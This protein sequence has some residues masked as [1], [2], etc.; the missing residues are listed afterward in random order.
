MASQSGLPLFQ[1]LPAG[2]PQPQ[3]SSSAARVE[4]GAPSQVIP[5][6]H[7]S[8][9]LED[10]GVHHPR[11]PPA[12]PLAPFPDLPEFRPFS[13]CELPESWEYSF[14]EDGKLVAWSPDASVPEG[15]RRR[16][17]VILKWTNDKEGAKVLYKIRPLSAPVSTSSRVSAS[18]T[19]D[20]IGALLENPRLNPE[21]HMFIDRSKDSPAVAFSP[22]AWFPQVK[23]EYALDIPALL[24]RSQDQPTAAPP[25]RAVPPSFPVLPPPIAPEGLRDCLWWSGRDRDLPHQ[26]CEPEAKLLAAESS[27][28]Q[29]LAS[30]ISSVTAVAMM[31]TWLRTL[32]VEFQNFPLEE[33]R[34]ALMALSTVAEGAANMVSVALPSAARTFAEACLAARLSAS[35]SAPDM[36]RRGLVRAA[37]L[38]RGLFDQEVTDRVFASVPAVIQ[39]QPPAPPRTRSVPAPRF[40][41]LAGRPPPFACQQQR[42]YRPPPSRANDQHPRRSRQ[43]GC[44]LP[45]LAC[46]LHE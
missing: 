36:A 14:G 44:G 7:H 43:H 41:S 11:S 18:N 34:D 13:W 17:D 27:A 35:R 29:D 33:L 23:G 5:P 37:P 38:Y 46:R 40:R 21:G 31:R 26:L 24:E 20:A 2:A 32:A 28:R 42:V 3:P 9:R 8:L 45:C 39:V 12:S 16:E 25:R 10:T 22:D 4:L 6:C 15:L 1:G 30:T 19:L